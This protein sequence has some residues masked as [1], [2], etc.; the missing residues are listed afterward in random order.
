MGGHLLS[1]VL[2]SVRDPKTGLRAVLDAP[3]GAGGRQTLF[4][5][6]AILPTL[7][8]FGVLS[9]AGAGQEFPLGPLILLVL[10]AGA[11][12]LMSFLAFA[13]GRWR[14]GI[15]SF[16]DCVVALSWLQITM[17]VA[18]VACLVVEL[19]LP[20]MGAIIGILALALM[21]WLATSFLAEVHGF[22]NTAMVFLSI[23]LTLFLTSF[24]LALLT[25][26]AGLGNV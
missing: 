15:G 8:I 13:V 14:G 5:L 2:L 11:L 19:A 26:L 7:L 17:V 3:L 9:V 4:A 18:Q 16:S 25:S 23:I 6:A 21:M 10:Q 12:L 24:V 1:L 22:R 20:F